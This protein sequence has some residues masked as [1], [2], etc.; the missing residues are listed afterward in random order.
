MLE[1]AL[2]WFLT[3]GIKLQKVVK[4]SKQEETGVYDLAA[5]TRMTEKMPK[6][7]PF[8]FNLVEMRTCLERLSFKIL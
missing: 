7:Q 6:V 2:T 3:S 1:I 4:D 5:E 8:V